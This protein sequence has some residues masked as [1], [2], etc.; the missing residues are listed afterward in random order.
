MAQYFEQILQSINNSEIRIA[1]EKLF[2]IMGVGTG[3]QVGDPGFV[4]NITGNVTGDQ[5]GNQV[6]DSTG[7]LLL[8]ETVSLAPTTH[9]ADGTLDGTEAW[10][11]MDASSAT[12]DLTLAA[13]N[14]GHYQ[15]FDCVDASNSC[16]V[17]LTVGD[18][19]GT[20]FIAT[21][22]A[23]EECLVVFAISATRFIIIE[24]IGAVALSGP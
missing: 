16:T 13:P 7:K 2:A 12:V 20:N 15:I 23:A 19:D 1:L 22:D 21:L 11:R 8:A 24:N 18:F 4:G 6:G 5:L 3:A 10:V 9:V 14:P 17:T